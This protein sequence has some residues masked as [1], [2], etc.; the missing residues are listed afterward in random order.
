MSNILHFVIFESLFNNFN[1][2]L[3]VSLLLKEQ[4]VLNDFY[5]VILYQL[6]QVYLRLILTN[7]DTVYFRKQR[8]LCSNLFII[9][10]QLILIYELS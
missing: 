9:F 8:S 10:R 3:D 5:F 7:I 6:K 2:D 1:W 4:I